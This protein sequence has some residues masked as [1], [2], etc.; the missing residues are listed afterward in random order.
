MTISV[1][2]SNESSPPIEASDQ[3]SPPKFLLVTFNDSDNAVSTTSRILGPGE[4]TVFHL[5]STS[6]LVV[7]EQGGMTAG[8]AAEGE[9][10]QDGKNEC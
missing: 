7:A 4:S 9:S 5:T 6:G 3:Q 2:V 1:R 10:E 8:E